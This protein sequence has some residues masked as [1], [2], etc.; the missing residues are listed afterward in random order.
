M[1]VAAHLHAG[2]DVDADGEEIEASASAAAAMAIDIVARLV[3]G[4]LALAEGP[5]A[6]DGHG[7]FDRSI[8][9]CRPFFDGR[10][11][12]CWPWRRA[13][14]A[15]AHTDLIALQGRMHEGARLLEEEAARF[16]QLTSAQDELRAA[17]QQHVFSLWRA[18]ELVDFADAFEA[19]VSGVLAPE[20]AAGV[21]PRL[22][23]AAFA[24]VAARYVPVRGQPANSERRW[25]AALL[26]AAMD[27]GEGRLVGA[28]LRL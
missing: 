13:H 14:T 22:K 10:A 25:A 9:L 1:L 8:E 4:V 28:L 2:E 20:A 7:R 24:A 3:T 21:D 6:A 11:G 19:V 12:R 15:A 26:I 23:D 16:R 18:E 27:V 17:G 5:A